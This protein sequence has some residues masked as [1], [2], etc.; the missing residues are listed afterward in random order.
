MTLVA[1]PQETSYANH[2]QLSYNAPIPATL[3]SIPAFR[4]F[5]PSDVTSICLTTTEPVLAAIPPPSLGI[6]I[7]T[8]ETNSWHQ[9]DRPALPNPPPPL[10]L[11]VTPPPPCLPQVPQ[12]SS[13]D[14][15]QH[16]RRTNRL[17]ENTNPGGPV[18]DPSSLPP[19][20]TLQR[21][22]ERKVNFVDNLVDSAAQ[23]VETIWPPQILHGAS[24]AP[25]DKVLPL[26]TFIQETLRRSRTSYSTL[27]VALYY[28]IVIRPFLPSRNSDFSSMPPED[29]QMVRAKQCGRRMFLAALILASKYLQDRNYSARAWSKISGLNTQE[30]NINE[31]AFL[32]A[33]NWRLHIS[34][35]IFNK[36]TDLVLKYTSPPGPCTLSHWSDEEKRKNEWCDLILTLTPH[37]LELDSMPVKGSLAPHALELGSMPAKGSLTPHALELDS[38]L[39]KGSITPHALE[40]ESMPA[41]GSS[42]GE[43]SPCPSHCATPT[44]F[45]SGKKRTCPENSDQRIMGDRIDGITTTT[46]IMK[47]R[48]F[49]S[50]IL[51]CRSPVLDSRKRTRYGYSGLEGMPLAQNVR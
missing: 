8:Q 30:I 44:G 24:A 28:L 15:K 39:A 37:A 48:G 36:W 51:N 12:S 21:Q 14:Q 18:P 11:E 13:T 47:L 10:V 41:K 50:P 33:I 4:S 1:T 35:T 20:P 6:R 31:M 45:S 3:A 2:P 17:L 9:S 23:I 29:A 7:Q 34:E 19:V 43:N 46:P 42:S 38:M 22:T 5:A 26:R 16:S 40:L 49:A 32:E 27:Q 25:K